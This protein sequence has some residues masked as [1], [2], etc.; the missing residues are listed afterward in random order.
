MGA[1]CVE[2]DEKSFMFAFLV[3][4]TFLKSPCINLVFDPAGLC[5]NKV[6]WV[7]AS[8]ERQEASPAPPLPAPAAATAAA[9]AAK[10]DCAERQCRKQHFSRKRSSSWQPTEQIRAAQQLTDEQMGQLVRQARHAP[11][12]PAPKLHHQH[13][14]AQ[15]RHPAAAAAAAV[16]RARKAPAA[17]TVVR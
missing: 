11:R 15:A 14:Q 9:T 12:L 7:A 5:V 4:C 8:H 17:V 1:C 6:F 13:A 2:C 16:R 10:A 3:Y